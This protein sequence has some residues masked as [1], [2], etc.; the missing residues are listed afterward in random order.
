MYTALVLMPQFLQVVQQRRTTESRLML[1]LM[2]GT[3]A[4]LA[5]HAE[6]LMKE[7]MNTKCLATG[8]CGTGQSA[9]VARTGRP[10]RC[11]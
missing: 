10:A 6:A 4:L 3:S 1:A 2:S 8:D 5:P 11:V 9:A 7:A